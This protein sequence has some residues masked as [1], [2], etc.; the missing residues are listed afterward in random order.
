MMILRRTIGT[1]RSSRPCPPSP[2]PHADPRTTCGHRTIGPEASLPPP[3]RV[4]C[5]PDDS[6]ASQALRL[7]TQM[8]ACEVVHPMW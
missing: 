5:H 1:M 2:A 7:P 4:E 6:A 3:R 8:R